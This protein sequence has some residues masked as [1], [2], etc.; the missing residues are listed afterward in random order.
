MT[1]AKILSSI[2]LFFPY[3]WKSLLFPVPE[4]NVEQKGED[5]GKESVWN[6]LSTQFT[7]IIYSKE[8]Q[9]KRR[10]KSNGCKCSGR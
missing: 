10:L 8:L 1:N 9:K 5:C 3:C 4:N 2:Q 6:V 7:V